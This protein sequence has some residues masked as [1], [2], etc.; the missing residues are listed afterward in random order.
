MISIQL[1][2]AVWIIYVICIISIFV[3]VSKQPRNEYN[4]IAILLVLMYGGMFCIGA[5]GV[6]SIIAGVEYLYWGNP[7]N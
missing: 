3:W 2:K 1:L 6:L 4:G 5:T 7:E